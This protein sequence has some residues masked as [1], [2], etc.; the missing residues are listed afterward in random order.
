MVVDQ[1]VPLAVLAVVDQVEHR[2]LVVPVT[3]H[4]IH[5]HKEIHLV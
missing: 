2:V 1:Q 5:H 3:L 4:H